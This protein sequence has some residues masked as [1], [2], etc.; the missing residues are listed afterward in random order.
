MSNVTMLRERIE[1]EW[2]AAWNVL[3]NYSQ[4]SSHDLIA[5]RVR[6][7][8]VLYDELKDHVGEETATEIVAQSMERMSGRDPSV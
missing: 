4:T 1:A 7:V 8:G 2:K 3:H 6:N 5:A